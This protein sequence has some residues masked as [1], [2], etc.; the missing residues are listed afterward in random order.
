MLCPELRRVIRRACAADGLELEDAARE[1][2]P[3]FEQRYQSPCDLRYVCSR[4]R[5]RVDEVARYRH[6]SFRALNKRRRSRP[7]PVRIRSRK[8]IRAVA[9]ITVSSAASIVSLIPFVPSTLDARSILSSSTIK[10]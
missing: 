4:Y 1:D 5:A 2:V 10:V 8:A 7:S 9:L 6:A 3:S